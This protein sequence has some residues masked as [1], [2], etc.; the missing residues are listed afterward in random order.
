MIDRAE[1]VNRASYNYQLE[2][3]LQGFVY[4]FKMKIEEV[5]V[6]DLDNISLRG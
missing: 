5:G 1:F 6:L 3:I 4:S 2:F